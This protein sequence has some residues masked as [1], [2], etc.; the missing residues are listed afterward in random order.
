MLQHK[1]SHVPN[2]PLPSKALAPSL[3]LDPGQL[4]DVK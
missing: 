3:L 4:V 2:S 1:L